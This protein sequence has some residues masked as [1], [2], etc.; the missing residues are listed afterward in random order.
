MGDIRKWMPTLLGSIDQSSLSLLI[1]K[2]CFKQTFSRLNIRGSSINVQFGEHM[3]P[4]PAFDLLMFITIYLV[5]MF[6]KIHFRY[7]LFIC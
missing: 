7:I 2:K 1:K 5:K 4:V 3:F 6:A